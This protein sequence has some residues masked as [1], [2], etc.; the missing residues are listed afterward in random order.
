MPRDGARSTDFPEAVSR[1]ATRLLCE[2]AGTEIRIVRGE[3]VAE[4]W[5]ARFGTYP[6]I[7]RCTIAGGAGALPDSVIVKVGRP[8]AHERGGLERL[9]NEWAALGFLASIG[10]AGGPRL[11]AAEAGIL[12]MEDLGT[13]PALEDLLVGSDPSAAE[14]G[15]VAFAEM[16][17]RMHATTAG[18]AAEYYQL[19]R[20]FGPVDP[21]FDRISILGVDVEHAW[22]QLREIIADRPYLPAPDGVGPDVDELLGVLSTPGPYLA[23]SNGDTCPQNCRMSDGAPRLIDFEHAAFRHALLDVAA[24]RF[25]FPACP[26][27]SHLP[28]DVGCRAEAVYRQALARSRPEVLDDESYAYGLTVACA[29]WTIVRMVRLPRL[30]MADKPHPLS[31]SRRGQ[32]LDTIGTTVRCAHQSRSLQTFAAWLAA[33]GDALGARWPRTAPTRPLYPAF[34]SRDPTQGRGQPPPPDPNRP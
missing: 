32:L 9:H 25:P 16:L 23:F 3:A 6:W 30:E 24:L 5:S 7:T 17:G 13:G 27:W 29:A 33:V 12:V 22:G 34:Q 21:A 19:R 31:F 10:S 11:L 26:C 20:R 8:E 4:G 18:H 14:H 1:R 15:V 28:D 2:Y